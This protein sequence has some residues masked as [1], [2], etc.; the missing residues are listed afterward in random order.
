MPLTLPL[1]R[2]R[3]I[4]SMGVR[5]E[6][7]HTDKEYAVIESLYERTKLLTNVVLRINEFANC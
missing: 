5:G 2:Y 7:N 6:M 4:C 1:Q 3:P